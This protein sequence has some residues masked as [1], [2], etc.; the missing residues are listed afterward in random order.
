M[1]R[2][3]P[4]TEVIN[5]VNTI[6]AVADLQRQLLAAGL[7]PAAV[8]EV[9]D[10]IGGHLSE[11][12]VRNRSRLVLGNGVPTAKVS[13]AAGPVRRFNG[14]F[15]I[16][17]QV[18]SLQ[19]IG[20]TTM[21][22]RE[23]SGGG[24]TSKPTK[25]GKSKA[26]VG[27]AVTYY[28]NN[29]QDAHPD[30]H[31]PADGDRGLFRGGLSVPF[32]R[33]AGHGLAEQALGHTVLNRGGEQSRYRVG[34]RFNVDTRSTSHNV[35]PT[36][37][38]VEAEVSVPRAEAAGFE[39]NLTGAVQTPSLRPG[40]GTGAG[41]AGPRVP[42]PR[43]PVLARPQG[44]MPSEAAYR[45]PTVLDRPVAVDPAHHEPLPLAA[46]RGIGFGM[47][48]LL[49]GAELV[50]QQI[51]AVMADR[52]GE[53]SGGRPAD[54]AQADL[55]LS[56]WFSRPAL[57]AD[58]P[59]VM[60]GIDRTITLGGRRYNV[61]VQ[62]FVGE[63]IG[64][65]GYEMTVNGRAMMAAGSSGHRNTEIG[66]QLSGGGGVRLGRLPYMRFILGAWSFQGEY[67]HT[68]KNE[69]GGTAKSYRRTETTGMVDEHNY[70]VVY[71]ITVRPEGE[72]ATTWW[73]DR[74]GDVTGRVVVPREHRPARPYTPQE[75]QNAGDAVTVPRLPSRETVNFTGAGT[76]GVYPAFTVIPELP[77]TAAEMYARANDLPR[78]WVDD[79]SN[80]P[81]AIRNMTRPDQLAAFFSSL[82]G[83]TGRTESLPPTRDGR[84]QAFTIKV[85]AQR[86]RHVG[87]S[88]TEIEQYAQ[89]QRTHKH[90][91]EHKVKGAHTFTAGP[92]FMLGSEADGHSSAPE[93][94]PSG[95][96]H[97]GPGGRVQLVVGSNVSAERK[98]ETADLHGNIDITRATYGGTAH[99]FQTDPVF[100]I[101]LHQWKGSRR[102]R[103]TRFVQ[104]TDGMQMMVPQRRMHDLG[105]SAP[106]VT[107]PE[108]AAPTRH[109]P[110]GM[111]AG[112]SYP[113]TLNAGGLVPRI[114]DW[115]REQGVVRGYF[116]GGNRPNMFTR[117]I[118]AAF[119]PE[120]LRNQHGAL[121]GSGVQRWIPIPQPFGGTR[122][123]WI[124]VSANLGA[125]TGQL[126]R[127]EVKL[128]LRGEGQTEHHR[129]VGT[130]FK[131]GG[132]F[133]IR[134]RGDGY[135][136]DGV[137]RHGGMEIKGEAAGEATQ[138]KEVHDRKL[139]IHRAGTREGSIEFHHP[140]R[141]QVEMGVSTEPP[142]LLNVPV[143]GIRET[144]IGTGRL[145]GGNDPRAGDRWYTRRPFIS[146]TV[147]EPDAPNA[148]TGDIRLLVP[149]HVATL[150]APAAPAPAFGGTPRWTPGRPA[151]G[152]VGPAERALAENLHPWGVPFASA[153]ERWA[154]LP[155]SP[156]RRPTG[157]ALAEPGAW[158]VPGLDFTT[159][160]GQRYM[161]FTSPELIRPYIGDLLHNRYT[162][163]VGSRNVTAGIEITAARP[164]GPAEDP[165]FKG[166]VYAQESQADKAKSGHSRDFKLVVG[167]EGGGEAGET[168][169]QGI[170]GYEYG[171][172]RAGE[173]DG[174]LGMTDE[175]NQ[176][177]TRNY[178]HFVFDVDVI[179]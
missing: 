8:K 85:H 96:E 163:P 52:H 136:S 89:G 146:H 132:T 7:P 118:E 154:A 22:I 156:Y 42:G 151:T 95:G 171:R 15:A 99:T 76:S 48:S 63:R 112:S 166:R 29:E 143:R 35:P 37:V 40:A 121:L 54:W 92:Q 61:S 67:A 50:H 41:G 117:E 107:P 139:D 1:Q 120:A 157:P 135:G 140:L 25:E 122:Y 70:N 97:H 60:A 4:A 83:S 62:G 91:T 101:T 72:R 110:P 2:P 158:H 124:R 133:E 30:A 9:M 69:F 26:S 179:L 127:P 79:P 111:I 155:A 13:M 160:A 57:E 17:A 170:G 59:A 169:T 173:T 176:E 137:H 45:R 64:G 65:D 10:E 3:S 34:L 164:V 39:E 31:H 130:A 149:G 106:G 138:G 5:A 90:G 14:H 88:E 131:Y 153:V 93:G 84:K 141:F 74:P 81:P 148:V 150:D 21:A 78:S 125:A 55:D 152:H 108:P 77:R 24:V 168:T 144:V 98:T 162:I 109:V 44:A 75:L 123:V 68:V 100:E 115:L 47:Q 51:R 18:E 87:A 104:V 134:G 165:R 28:G 159:V 113:E 177:A 175:A 119:S 80:W 114:M 172:D 147:I 128:T 33:S 86:P 11:K 71:E 38:V 102:N 129:S 19:Y 178:R 161:H 43:V 49:P 142:E 94:S 6:P 145:L 46:R 56:T 167:P 116:P 23:D 126:P 103:Q 12:S 20:D 66:V 16:S 32:S 27:Y 53:L 58:L 73:I 174:E 105:L 82:A 36:S